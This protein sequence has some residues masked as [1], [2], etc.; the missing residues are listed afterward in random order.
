MN[1]TKLEKIFG[2]NYNIIQIFLARP[3][4][5][6]YLTEAARELQLNKMT[7]YRALEEMIKCDILESRTDNYRKFYRLRKSHLI[8]PLKI[9]VNLDSRVV[10]EFFGKFKSKSHSIILYGSRAGGTD[11]ADSDWD[12]IL[13]S[14]ELDLV[15]INRTIAKLEKKYLT[16]INVKLYSKSEYDDIRT[17]RTPFYLEIMANNI[18]LKGEP[19][20]A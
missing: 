6:F 1:D 8:K 17:S 13:V 15:T 11:L 10:G 5:E 7:L 12:F 14:D 16:K 18:L 4:K 19:D 20:E 2:R 9:L 3:D